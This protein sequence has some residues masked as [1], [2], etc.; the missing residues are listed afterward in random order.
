MNN[1]GQMCNLTILFI[2]QGYTQR[3]KDVM[4]GK[5]IAVLYTCIDA[6]VFV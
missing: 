2:V 3:I 6:S 1:S 5:L 4:Q